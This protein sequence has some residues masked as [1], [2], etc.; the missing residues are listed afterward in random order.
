MHVQFLTG[1]ATAALLKACI[2][3]SPQQPATGTRSIGKVLD[4][5]FSKSARSAD[6]DTISKLTRKAIDS[7]L[8]KKE[9]KHLAAEV[10]RGGSKAIDEFKA[11]SL[12]RIRNLMNSIQMSNATMLLKRAI[13]GTDNKHAEIIYKYISENKIK[14]AV[15]YTNEHVGSLLDD[16]RLHRIARSAGGDFDKAAT[17]LANNHKLA[18]AIG[19]ELSNDITFRQL[20][21]TAEEVAAELKI[22]KKDIDLPMSKSNGE[23]MRE[24]RLVQELTGEDVWSELAHLELMLRQTDDSKP[25]YTVLTTEQIKALGTPFDGEKT[26]FLKTYGTENGYLTEFYRGPTKASNDALLQQLL[27]EHSYVGIID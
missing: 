18:D 16:K 17:L 7:N 21:I 11:K 1:L 10:V 8:T 22:G 6:T 9:V 19:V 27:E 4:D 3:H 15:S 14:K 23:Y 24:V 5:V 12:Y 2:V 25:L 26:L 20:N 13:D